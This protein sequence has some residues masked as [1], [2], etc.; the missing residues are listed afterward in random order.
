MGPREPETHPGNICFGE[1]EEKLDYFFGGVIFFGPRQHQDVE[2]ER[3][4]SQG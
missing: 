1:G 4:C 3:S 2:S